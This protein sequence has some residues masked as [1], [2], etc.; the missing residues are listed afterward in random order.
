MINEIRK[1]N[2]EIRLLASFDILASPVPHSYILLDFKYHVNS[3]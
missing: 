1:N 3:N 2:F